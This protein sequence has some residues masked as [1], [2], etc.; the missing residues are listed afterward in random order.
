[1]TRV[2]SKQVTDHSLPDKQI[3]SKRVHT[4]EIKDPDFGESYTVHLRKEGNEWRGWI[5]D[6]PGVECKGQTKNAL[7]KI[8]IGKLQEALIALEYLRKEALEDIKDG[9]FT[10]LFKWDVLHASEPAEDARVVLRSPVTV[11]DSQK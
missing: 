4:I 7:L 5:P 3:K 6:V 11:S 2:I 9:K 1:M 8:L 10:D